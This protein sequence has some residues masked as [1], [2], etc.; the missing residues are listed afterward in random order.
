M[1]QGDRARIEVTDDGAGIAPDDL[2]RLFERFYRRDKSR[3][4]RADGGGNGL[5]LSIAHAIVDA[6]GG[7]IAVRSTIGQGTTFAVLFAARR[8]N[9]AWSGATRPTDNPC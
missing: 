8:A 3:A 1:R 5:G 2:R 9:Q 4:R 6:H 7:T